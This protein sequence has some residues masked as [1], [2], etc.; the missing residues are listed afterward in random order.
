VGDN[1]AVALLDLG[2]VAEMDAENRG[3]FAR[4]FGAWVRGDGRTMADLM[5]RLSPSET[6]ADRAGFEAAIETF[7]ARWRGLRLGEVEAS[8]VFFEMMGI[9][10]RFRVRANATF[11]L[12]NIAIAVTEGIGKQLDPELDLFAEALPFFTGLGATQGGATVN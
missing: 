10:R 2:L 8:K 7:V 9:L 5:A 12:V 1:G 4:Y 3:A 6:I 11:T